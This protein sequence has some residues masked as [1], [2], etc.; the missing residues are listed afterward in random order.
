MFNHLIKIDKILLDPP[1]AQTIINGLERELTLFSK[2]FSSSHYNY[3]IDSVAYLDEDYPL[4]MEE[5]ISE[6]EVFLP[7]VCYIGEVFKKATN[8]EWEIKKNK[9][10]EVISIKGENG[11]YYDP[12]A[13]VQKI[14]INAHHSHDFQAVVESQLHPINFQKVIQS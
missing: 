8:G 5:G 14:L 10:K 4:L 3:S 6:A 9:K 13:P 11:I 7:I 12:Y 2:F 1:N